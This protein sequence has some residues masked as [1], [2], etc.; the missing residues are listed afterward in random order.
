MKQLFIS[1]FN[2]NIYSYEL[3]TDTYR[4]IQYIGVSL[5][6]NDNVRNG[7]LRINITIKK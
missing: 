7:F 6:K 4:Y 5:M 1:P 2:N 3:F